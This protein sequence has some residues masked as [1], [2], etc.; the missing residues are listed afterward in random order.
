MARTIGLGRTFRYF[1][2]GLGYRLESRFNGPISP[3]INLNTL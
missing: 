1:S 3:S 2:S